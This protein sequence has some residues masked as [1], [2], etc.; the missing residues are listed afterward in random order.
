LNSLRM[1]VPTVTSDGGAP[2]DALKRLSMID[3]LANL[4]F[5]WMVLHLADV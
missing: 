2:K 5:G 4:R 3:T 1:D